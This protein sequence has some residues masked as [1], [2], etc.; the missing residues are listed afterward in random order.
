MTEHSWLLDLDKAVQS[1][2]IRTMPMKSGIT[3]E[4]SD[5]ESLTVVLLKVRFR[6]AGKPVARIK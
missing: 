3:V 1:M 6:K 2:R 5:N 4:G